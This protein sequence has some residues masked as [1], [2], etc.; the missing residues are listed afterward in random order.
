MVKFSS[1]H[2][3]RV[4][5]LINYSQNDSFAN[6]LYKISSIYADIIINKVIL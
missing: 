6:S 5:N 4:E 1:G 3:E 2:F